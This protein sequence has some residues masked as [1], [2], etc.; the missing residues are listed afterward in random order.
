M[1]ET[2]DGGIAAGMTP[3]FTQ[4]SQIELKICYMRKTLLVLL[5]YLRLCRTFC[6]LSDDKIDS[7]L[8]R[9]RC[10][11]WLS[12]FQTHLRGDSGVNTVGVEIR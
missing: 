11:K 12:C 1:H 2:T 10:A 8:E 3:M 9:S 4:V 5:A 7:K 6:V